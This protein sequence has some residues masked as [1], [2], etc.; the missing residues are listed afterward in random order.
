MVEQQF[1]RNISYKYRIGDLLLGKPIFDEEKFSFLE[2]GDRR[3]VRVNIVGNIIEKYESEGETNYIFLKLDDGSGQ[4]SLKIF[5][6]DVKKFRDFLQGDTVLVI[7]I[8]RN[9]NNET[10]IA[11]EIIRKVDVKYLLI[12]KLEIENQKKKENNN[13]GREQIIAVKD[14]ILNSIKN[15]EEKGGI[16]IDELIMNLRDVSSEIIEQE[17]KKLVEEGIVFEPRPGKVR[18]LG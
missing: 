1:K 7:G 11:P 15:S 10:Y 17:V 2:L 13:L 16:E 4:I 9:F 6:D 3:I 14:R 18:Y 12:R 8:L 5:G